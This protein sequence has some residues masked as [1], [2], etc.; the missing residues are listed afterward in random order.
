MEYFFSVL[1]AMNQKI[2]ELINNKIITINTKIGI[3]GADEYS[4][5]IRTLL[6]HRGFDVSAYLEDNKSR[7]EKYLSRVRGA[8]ARYFNKTEAYIHVYDINTWKKL[9]GTNAIILYISNTIDSSINPIAKI[10]GSYCLYDWDNNDQNKHIKGKINNDELKKIEKDI[11]Y[12]FDKFCSEHK[13][14]YWVSGGTMLGT[15]R[16]KGFIPWDDDIDVFMPDVDYNKFLKLFKE[17]NIYKLQI[18]DDEND[19]WG[20]YKF[21]RLANKETLL[22]ENDFL[23]RHYIGVNIEILPIV[24]LPQTEEERVEYIRKY[25]SMNKLRTKIFYDSD[26]N[27]DI[28]RKKCNEEMEKLTPR[29]FDD[30]DYVGVLGTGYYERDCTT[31]KVYEETLRL[32]FEDI[33]VN[34]PVG[35]KEYLDNLYGEG[36]EK[37]PPQSKQTLKHN[38]E[39]YWL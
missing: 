12:F 21:C 3:L 29:L 5:S 1:D 39:A 31:R 34:V 7:R 30:S 25:D 23:Y 26:G 16:H 36:W 6:E 18:V 32:P 22:I 35:Y 33:I 14:R 17:N 15:L 20:H 8:C 38:M 27:M 37:I 9:V 24:G 19:V 4:F 11:L 13:L 2:K 10:E 28:F